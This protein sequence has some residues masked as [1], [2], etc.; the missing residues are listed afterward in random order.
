[1]LILIKYIICNTYVML[2]IINYA[3]KKHKKIMKLKG[4]TN[5]SRY[6]T[7]GVEIHR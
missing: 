1:M 7:I 6:A 4:K 5:N 2:K 3:Y